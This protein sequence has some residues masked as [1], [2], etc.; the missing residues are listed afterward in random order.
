M[1]GKRGQS[2]RHNIKRKGMQKRHGGAV[3]AY[4]K[5]GKGNPEETSY[6]YQTYRLSNREAVQ[7]VGTICLL[8]AA[9]SLLFY[10]TWKVMPLFWLPGPWIWNR[11]KQQ[12]G[13]K[14]REAL[15][16]QFLTGMQLVST[17]LRAGYAMENTFRE[18]LPQLEETYGSEAPVVEEFRM[19]SSKIRLNCPV[20]TL[21]TDLGERSGVED[22]RSFAEVFSAARRTGGDLLAIVAHTIDGLERKA[23]TQSEIRAMLAGKQMERKIM[24]LSP[25]AIL[26]YIRLTSPEFLLPLYGSAVGRLLMSACL[27]WY[28]AAY[29]WGERILSIRI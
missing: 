26:G 12:L 3:A 15:A 16:E 6:Q 9:I 23:D 13:Q 2:G 18:T 4:L 28:G 29:L 24:S 19:I 22:I 11:R 8:S 10:N 17:A 14:R 7:T 1:Y 25:L 27:V 20:E 21:L 5:T